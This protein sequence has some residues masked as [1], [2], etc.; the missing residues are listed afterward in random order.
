MDRTQLE[1]A[2]LLKSHNQNREERRKE[3]GI[4]DRELQ[5]Q[6][7][8]REKHETNESSPSKK[9]EESIF[10]NSYGISRKINTQTH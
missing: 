10:I 9:S 1:N 7:A 2:L 5:K 8:E 6:Y 4:T 3:L